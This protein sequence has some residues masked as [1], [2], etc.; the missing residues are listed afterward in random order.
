MRKNRWYARID[1]ISE[2]METQRRNKKHCNINEECLW[3]GSSIDWTCSRKKSPGR[4]FQIWNAKGKRNEQMEQYQ[5]LR[6]NYKRS[7]RCIVQIW[8]GKEKKE[9]SY[10]NNGLELKIKMTTTYKARK[11]GEHLV[12]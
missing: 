5:E 12:A 1:N 8:A 9:K 10:L 11:L 4:N 3:L 2:R 7:N 6:E